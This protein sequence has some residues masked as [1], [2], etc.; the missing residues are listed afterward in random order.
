MPLPDL[1]MTKGQHNFIE[2]MTR[3]ELVKWCDEA[4]RKGTTSI[5]LDP[6]NPYVRHGVTKKFISD[7][8]EGWFKVL[9]GGWA[10]GTSFLKR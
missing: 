4:T 10:A 2:Q 5:Q 9:S 3:H 6:K 7:K 1:S 8:G